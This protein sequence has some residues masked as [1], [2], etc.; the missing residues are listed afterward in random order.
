MFYSFFSYWRIRI[1]T[2]G[3][4]SKALVDENQ[5]EEIT[6]FI[7]NKYF[8]VFILNILEKFPNEVDSL[9]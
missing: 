8:P 3:R 6:C 1:V 2:K 4:S 7:E 9:Q 5:K